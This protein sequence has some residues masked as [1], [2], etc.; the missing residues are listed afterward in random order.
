ML[1]GTSRGGEAWPVG[2]LFM[3]VFH[4]EPRPGGVPGC[5]QAKDT[6][7][8]SARLRESPTAEDGWG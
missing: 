1:W 5:T 6:T 3:G 7:V 8:R 4:S 2:P